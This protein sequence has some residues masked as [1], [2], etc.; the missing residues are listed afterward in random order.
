MN[1]SE[2]ASYDGLGLAGLVKNGD[3]SPRELAATAFQAIEKM[4]PV[5]N[6]VVET[7][8]DRISSLD[9]GSLGPGLFRGV[10][11]LIKD[12]GNYEAGRKCE[13]GSRLLQGYVAAHDSFFIQ[14]LRACGL[15]NIGRTNV[16]EF[17]IAGTTENVLYGN[18]SNPWRIGYSAGGSSGGAAAAVAA[19]IVPMAHGS[20]IGGSIRIP[21]AYCGGVGMKPSRG[22][23]SFGPLQ[24][25]RGWGM[26]TMLGQTRTV[27][28][29]AALLDCFGQPQ[30]GDPFI[31]KQPSRAYL[32]EVG[33][34]VGKLRIAF[35]TTPLAPDW[36]V[37]SE[38]VAATE[39]T[40]KILEGQGHIVVEDAPPFDFEGLLRHFNVVWFFGFDRVL[41]NLA[42]ELG[43]DIGPD[44]LE[45]CTLDI[46][47]HAK[48]I[49]PYD[50]FAAFA[51]F[52]SV[53]RDFGQFFQQYDV[54]LTPTTSRPAEPWGLYNQSLTGM[55][56]EGRSRIAESNYQFCSL[57]NLTGLPSIS[58]P[59]FA[60]SNHLPIGIQLGARHGEEELLIRVASALEESNPWI[61]R[62]PPLH[63]SSN[64]LPSASTQ[65]AH[66]I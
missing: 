15:N 25:E 60:T 38:T 51:F 10:P 2:Y 21:A 57:Y 64:E 14:Q 17:C 20:D 1:L 19:G 42:S 46:Y 11:F 8:D 7:Y 36:P 58:L 26:A 59:L 50:L 53:R 56:V 16:P 28:D 52:N 44:T 3:V 63:V 40:A 31:I 54:W 49:D 22:R 43:R 41:E 29:T 47:H 66:L 12:V 5:L 39:H 33:A 62:T 23:I 45:P 6:A 61:D 48:T 9:E 55:S 4:N 24:D 32:D 27:R 37:E 18:T 34:P 13:Q 65:Q 30:P 35:S